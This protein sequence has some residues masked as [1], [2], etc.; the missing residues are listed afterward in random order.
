MLD[1]PQL[2]FRKVG[3]QIGVSDAAVRY[4]KK[5]PIWEEQ[6]QLILIERAEVLR[7]R[8]QEKGE[9]DQQELEE[10]RKKL[11]AIA[12]GLEAIAAHSINTSGTAYKQASR[13]DDAIKACSKLSK[14]GVDRVARTG[15]ETVKAL[16]QIYDQLDQTKVL[17]EYY[18]KI[19]QQENN[20]Q[21]TLDI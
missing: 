5:L 6:R 3:E 4:W 1:N 21:D 2:S 18:Q 19:E 9:E 13:S 10:R 16:I 12:S 8:M 14:S 11:R 17:A 20:P 15:I 7:R